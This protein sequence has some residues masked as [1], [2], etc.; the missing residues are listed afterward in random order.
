ML[1]V[2]AVSISEPLLIVADEP[3]AL[4]DAQNTKL[5]RH[6][7]I[8]DAPQT[9]VLVTH[10]LALAERCDVALRFADGRLVATGNAR[11]IVG[12]YR[13]DVE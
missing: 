8:D 4:L 13:K 9:V 12:T 2:A 5:M 7:L 10:D 11:D 1:A 6:H 3:T